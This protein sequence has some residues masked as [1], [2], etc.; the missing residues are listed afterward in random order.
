MKK[1]IRQI[2]NYIQLHTSDMETGDYVDLMREL[3]EWSTSQA[4]KAEYSDDPDTV[5]PTDE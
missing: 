3:A 5:F 4:D 1:V 2:K